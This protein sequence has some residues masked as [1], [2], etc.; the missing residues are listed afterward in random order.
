MLMPITTVL[1][2]LAGPAALLA[3]I[4][5]WFLRPRRRL[6]ALPAAAAD[7]ALMRA[8]YLALP[9]LVVGAIARL[10]MSEQLDFSLV[11]VLVL[12]VSALVWALDRYLFAPQRARAAE[13]A[14]VAPASVALPVTVDYA[15]SF[16]PVAALV[17]GLRSFVVCVT[18]HDFC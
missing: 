1:A 2:W 10:L 6:A 17:L 9:V 12:L 15:R 13:R 7:P 5:D 18:L 3:M 16:L 8:V 11:L 4:D 14:G